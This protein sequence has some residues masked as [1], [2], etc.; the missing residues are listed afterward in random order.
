MV[1]T[2]EKTKVCEGCSDLPVS[3][4]ILWVFHTLSLPLL[5][6]FFLRFFYDSTRSPIKFL[7]VGERQLKCT[8]MKKKVRDFFYR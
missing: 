5:F 6:R 1:Q 2:T 4:I 7:S 8:F 3:L